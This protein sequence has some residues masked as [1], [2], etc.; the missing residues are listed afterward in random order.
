MSFVITTPFGFNLDLSFFSD[1][2]INFLTFQPLEQAG[3]IVAIFGWLVMGKWFFEIGAQ[4]WRTYRQNLY[5]ARWQWVLL[6]VDVP[7]LFIQTPKA[8]EQI[9]A[10]LSGISTHPHFGEEYWMGKKQKYFSLE[11]VSIEGYIQFLIRTEAGNRDL[12]EAA[13]YA[14]YP[15]AEITEVEEYT[16]VI[17]D[18]YPNDDYDIFGVDFVL[19]Q[20]EAYP[21]RTHSHFES[22]ISKDMVFS[23]PM[24]AILENFTRIGQG[25]DLWLQIIIEPAGSHWKEHGIEVVKELLG[26]EAH[27]GGGGGIG[28]FFDSIIRGILHELWSIW[29]WNFEGVEHE[30]HEE[31]GAKKMSDLTPGEKTTIEAIEEKIS[32]IGFKSKIRALY[33]AHHNVYNPDH[34]IDGLIGALS[35]FHQLNGNSIVPFAI[36]H[37]LYAMAHDRENWMKTAFVKAFKKRKMKYL[38]NPYVLNIE[39]LATIW[40]FPLPF[41]KAP[42]LQ[43]ANAKRAEPPINLPIEMLDGPLRRKGGKPPEA[44]PPPE[45]ELP[46][47]LPYG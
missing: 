23:D 29:H 47:E 10:H 17:P 38:G 39:E 6:A 34:C 42:L 43:K 13:V 18:K 20:N 46:Q 8:V 7:P 12:V 21:I 35:Q 24:A 1:F 3:A 9:F 11:I 27:H 25:E 26:Q 32:K 2:L 36:T 4:L 22:N 15:E 37:K 14:Q 31:S 28:S 41:V 44:P 33:A 45:P 40:H 30:E 19:E 5:T 16:S